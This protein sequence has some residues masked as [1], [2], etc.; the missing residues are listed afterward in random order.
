MVTGVGRN[1]GR[2][3]VLAWGRPFNVQSGHGTMHSACPRSPHCKWKSELP[4]M[5]RQFVL[6]EL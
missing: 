5:W 2:P 4:C 1:V 3:Q 6:P